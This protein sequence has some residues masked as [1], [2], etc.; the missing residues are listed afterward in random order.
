VTINPGAGN[1]KILIVDD[2]RVIRMAAKKI[3]SGHYEFAEAGDGREALDILQRDAGFAAILSDLSMPN[4]G[5]MDLLQAMRTSDSDYL[6]HVP[7]IIVTGAEDDDGTKSNAL[8]AGASD[9]ITKPFDAVQLL[10]RIKAQTE[11][12]QKSRELEETAAT[13]EHH[14]TIDAITGLANSRSFHD[15]GTQAVAYAIRHRTDLALIVLEADQQETLANIEDHREP[16]AAIAR[17]IARILRRNI[18]CE[19]IAARLDGYRFA[20]LSP[21]ANAIGARGLA[22][23]VCAEIAGWQVPSVAPVGKI[24][25]SAGI[26]TPD[27]HRDTRLD[28]LIKEADE[29]VLAARSSGGNQVIY[30]EGG[31]QAP[32]PLDIPTLSDLASPHTDVPASPTAIGPSLTAPPLSDWMPSA[33]PTLQSVAEAPPPAEPDLN[34]AMQLLKSGLVERLEPHLR[35]LV[36]ECL[37]LLDHWNRTQNLQLEPELDRIRQACREPELE[38]PPFSPEATSLL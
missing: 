27:I 13:L 4:M 12:Q 30:K 19:D 16:G 21:G 23:R 14:T 9:F 38:V 7:V 33:T 22:R 26:V 8:A 1:P 18:R 15:Q 29:R 31:H 11:V 24:T 6:R 28:D 17:Q 25:L 37:P 3:L 36:R 10:A 20:L 2:S 32:P 35:T 34:R 5:G